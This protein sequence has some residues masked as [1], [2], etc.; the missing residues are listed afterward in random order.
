MLYADL[1]VIAAVDGRDHLRLALALGPLQ[2]LS[3]ISLDLRGKCSHLTVMKR[4]H[5]TT[6]RGGRFRFTSCSK[7]WEFGIRGQVHI[8]LY[9]LGFRV[10]GL[11]LRV[12]G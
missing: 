11:G 6:S 5:F 9:S 7:V 8:L 12:E 1:R 3:G 2:H 10:Q 4:S